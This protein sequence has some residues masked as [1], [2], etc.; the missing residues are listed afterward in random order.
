[1]SSCGRARHLFGSYWD[2]EVTQAER[3]WLEAHFHS[4]A[5]CH[6]EYE[7]LAH[8]LEAVAALPREEAAPDLA[9]RALAAARRAA[10]APDVIYVREIP[11]WA[12]LT[13]AA[14]AVLLVVASLAPFLARTPGGFTMAGRGAAVP[15]ARLLATRAD[16][17]A[18][19]GA[20]TGT[21]AS[22]RVASAV[23]DSLFD[24]SEDVDFVLDPVR[25]RGGRAHGGTRL[26]QA[27]QGEQ[28]VITF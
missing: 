4:C 20:S 5:G 18:A 19:G 10:P 2:D 7:Q 8:A 3:E 26:P 24:H 16:G 11:G 22:G 17:S 6:A 13:A 9:V 15:E 14:T 23:V 12:P 28:T 21:A 27:V 1:M 25:L